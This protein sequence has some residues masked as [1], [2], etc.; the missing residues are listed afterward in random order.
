[1]KRWLVVAAAIVV[2]FAGDRTGG[3]ALDELLERSP[4]R[5][6]RLYSGRMAA[7][8]VCL[9]NSRGMFSLAAPEIAKATGRTA[10][11]ISYNGMTVQIARALFADYVRDNGAPKLL[12][13][14]GSFVT[15][16]TGRG[17]VAEYKPWFNQSPG[18]LA[19]GE[20]YCLS[21]ANATQLTWLYR[22]NSELA[23]R[24]LYYLARRQSDQSP[25]MTG[26]ISAKLLEEV[27]ESEPAALE[28]QPD[29]LAALKNLVSEARAAGTEVKIVFA[30]YLPAYA[31]KITN[32]KSMMDEVSQATG[33]EVVDI[34]H[35]ISDTKLFADRVH[36]NPGGVAEATKLLLERGVFN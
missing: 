30:P 20:K 34:T 5:F 12:V 16:E 2:F 4:Q 10:V 23:L 17:L 14:E 25:R 9:G 7:D 13:I 3:L 11:N 21:E 27:E 36:L 31:D 6:C 29:E 1:M 8:I 33:S 24:A 28:V 26:S 35:S 32:L 22:Y 15:T 19:L 18:L